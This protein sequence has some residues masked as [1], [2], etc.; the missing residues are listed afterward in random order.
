MLGVPKAASVWPSEP[1][2][3]RQGGVG[4]VRRLRT[5]EQFQAVLAA[6]VVARTDQFALHRL[7][8]EAVAPRQQVGANSG[9]KPALF[10]QGGLWLGAL[11][12]KRWAPRAVSRILI[13]RQIHQMSAMHEYLFPQ[14]AH[15]VRLRAAFDQRQFISAAS[16]Q[17]REAVA[18]QLCELF[19]QA[20]PRK[21]GQARP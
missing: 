1:T 2:L 16:C 9:A 18:E 6:A 7:Q 13:K 19:R 12:P 4:D 20:A 11:V 17:L 3:D 15:V 10:C 21:P 5:R 8:H 14:A